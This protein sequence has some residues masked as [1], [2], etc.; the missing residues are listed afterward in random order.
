M[1]NR[2]GCCQ[3]VAW[4]FVIDVVIRN[5]YLNTYKNLLFLNLN[6]FNLNFQRTLP[7]T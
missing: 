4:T 2:V 5:Y 1:F 7:L 6:N 3:V